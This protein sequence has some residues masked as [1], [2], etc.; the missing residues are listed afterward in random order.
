M[1]IMESDLGAGMT[2]LAISKITES[3]AES[4]VLTGE[5]QASGQSHNVNRLMML[6]VKKKF[7][8]GIHSVDQTFTRE[9]GV[10]RLIAQ[11]A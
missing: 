8:Y 2:A 5:D 9:A 11:K 3:S 6:S 10:A 4:Q 1:A 7:S